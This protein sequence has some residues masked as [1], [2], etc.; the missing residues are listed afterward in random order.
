M[1]AKR[2]DPAAQDDLPNSEHEPRS[3]RAAL[4][5][6]IA[7]GLIIIVIAW[8]ALSHLIRPS[9]ERVSEDTKV[10]YVVND[11]YSARNSLNYDLYRG[12]QC[13]ANVASKDFPTA[14]Q[15]AEA[16]RGPLERDGK[17]VVP[18]MDV[19]VTGSRAAVTVHAHRENTEDKKTTTDVT[20]VKQGE[21]WKVCAS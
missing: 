11:L 12:A 3:W 17:I 15:F 10:Q 16:N 6:L 8:I 5:F 4:P 18:E 2:P 20:V 7:F 19:E 14:A 13:E 9:E 21:D 1:S